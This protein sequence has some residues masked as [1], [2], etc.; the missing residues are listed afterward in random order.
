MELAIK[1]FCDRMSAWKPEEV[2]RVLEA[3]L[4]RPLSGADGKMSAPHIQWRKYWSTRA[5]S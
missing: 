4:G 2:I 1:N 5:T 3:E